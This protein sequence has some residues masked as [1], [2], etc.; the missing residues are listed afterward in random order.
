M[1]K[2]TP[3]RLG[4]QAGALAEAVTGLRRTVTELTDRLAAQESVV[5]RQTRRIA[6]QRAAIWVV[7]VL[8]LVVLGGGL[9]VGKQVQ[10]TAAQNRTTDE[11]LCPLLGLFLAS[12]RP[13]T[14]PP[15]RLDFYERA[16]TELRRMHGVLSCP[17]VT[18]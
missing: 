11:V 16:F 2:P 6:R 14:Q 9:L 12:Y 8:L 13:E 5:D 4:A 7:A 3:E 15:D 1:S 18:R 10:L 17:E